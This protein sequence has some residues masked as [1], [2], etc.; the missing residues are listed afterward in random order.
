M[1]KTKTARLEDSFTATEQRLFRLPELIQRVAYNEA[2]LNE[3][4][5]FGN[6]SEKKSS[7]SIVRLIRPTMRVD[8][9]EAKRA[10]I[11]LLESYITADR[12][13]IRTMK[14]ALSCIRD[15]PYYLTIEYKY[16][17]KEAD[18][19]IAKHLNCALTTIRR[20]RANLVR[21][22]STVLYGV[23]GA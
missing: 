8:P 7:R 11:R 2:D 5:D 23:N 20:N 21:R 1:K 12:Y 18:E 15:D 13:E 14:R 6:I 4:V 3:L 9:V 17:R 22:I 19:V 10:Q 16:F